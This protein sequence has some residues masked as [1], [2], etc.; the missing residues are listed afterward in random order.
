[1]KVLIAELGKSN[2]ERSADSLVFGMILDNI[3][4]NPNVRTTV[5]Y[6]DFHLT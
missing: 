3:E 6:T 4:I 1:M 5:H 2:N